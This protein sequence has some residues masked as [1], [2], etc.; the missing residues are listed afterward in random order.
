MAEPNRGLTV[1]ASAR[2]GREGGR[3]RGGVGGGWRVVHRRGAGIG[4]GRSATTL[5]GVRG[6][7]IV[8]AVSSCDDA[9]SYVPPCAR[10]IWATM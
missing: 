5:R 6:Q 4:Y 10:A 8:N 3:R 1:L 7:V 9:T 2:R